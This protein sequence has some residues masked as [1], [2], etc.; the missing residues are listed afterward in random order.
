MRLDLLRQPIAL[1]LPL[2]CTLLLLAAGCAGTVP[3]QE[4]LDPDLVARAVQ[5]ADALNAAGRRV[6]CVPFARNASGIEIRGNAGTWW[7]KA[8][9]GFARGHEPVVGAVMAFS[10]TRKLPLGHVAVV[11]DVVSEREIRIDHA[12]WHRSKVSLGMAVIDVSESNDWSAVRVESNPDTFGRIY[13]IDGFISKG[14]SASGKTVST[15]GE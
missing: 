4:G 6:W 12:N 11:S 9:D 14:G 2:L 8:K 5:E 7:S 1:R 13:S 15:K 3:R 10:A